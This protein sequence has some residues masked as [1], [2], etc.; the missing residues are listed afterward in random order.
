MKNAVGAELPENI[1]AN[2]VSATIINATSTANVKDLNADKI[3][4]ASQT[5]YNI[6]AAKDNE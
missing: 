2:I 5:A 1:T 3:V 6:D 4:V